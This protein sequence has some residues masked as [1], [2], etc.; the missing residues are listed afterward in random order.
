[1]MRRQI[2]NGW[3][4]MDTTKKTDPRQQRKYTFV[5][6]KSETKMGTGIHPICGV[7]ELRM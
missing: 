6:I 5:C 4:S 2:A 7:R 1:M 3:N